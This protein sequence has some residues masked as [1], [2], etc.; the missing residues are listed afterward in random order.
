MHASS[1]PG[2]TGGSTAIDALMTGF[3]V[4]L[5]GFAA[6]DKLFHIRGFIKALNSY[7]LL[8][9]P[10]GEY[11]APVII[12]AELMTA[13]ALLRPAWRRDAALQAAVLMTMFTI[14]L[15]GNALSGKDAICGCWFSISMAQGN[16]HFVLNGLV[17]AMSLLIWRGAAVPALLADGPGQAAHGR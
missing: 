11:L 6:V 1:D 2:P 10:M 3:L 5:F 4:L 17:I 13:I 12:A 7:R 8:P 9:V 15:I 16:V 14:G